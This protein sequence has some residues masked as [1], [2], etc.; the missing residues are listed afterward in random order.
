MTI[1]N[2]KIYEELIEN[3]SECAKLLTQSQ[4]ALDDGDLALSQ[5]YFLQVKSTLSALNLDTFNE[6]KSLCNEEI[7]ESDDY[8]ISSLNLA[9]LL[10][11]A[12]KTCG[13]LIGMELDDEKE[14]I[15]QM[16]LSKLIKTLNAVSEL[17]ETL[18]N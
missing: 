4:I 6:I 17:F 16:M 7:T 9:C 14:N 3:A 12:V 11:D 15:K 8:D 18:F 2:I 5:K 10:D 1:E 13:V